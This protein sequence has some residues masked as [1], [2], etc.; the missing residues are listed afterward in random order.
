MRATLTTCL[1]LS[2]SI[3][4]GGKKGDDNG[5]DNGVDACKGIECQVV[6]CTAMSLPPTTLTGTV[7]A[8]NGT[9]PLNGVNVYVPRDPLPPFTEGVT[10]DR[11]ATTLPGSAVAQTVSDA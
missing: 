8:P 7:F 1:L 6:N 2:L 9:L 10:C 4:C 5:D 11:C 3:G